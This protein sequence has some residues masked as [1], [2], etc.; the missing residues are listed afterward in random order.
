M[1]REEGLIGAYGAP[2]ERA[3]RGYIDLFKD[4][5]IGGVLFLSIL[6]L[7]LIILVWTIWWVW[8]STSEIKR[9]RTIVA[10]AKGATEG[11]RQAAFALRYAEIHTGL[12]ALPRIGACWREFSETL[13]RPDPDVPEGVPNHSTVVRN[14]RRPQEYFTLSNAGMSATVLRSWPGIL[15]GIGLVLTFVGL[16]AALGTAADSLAG[17][18][19]QS[20]MVNALR[21]LLRTAGAKFY[22]SATALACSIV[23]GLIQRSCLKHLAGQMHALNDALEERLQFDPMASTSRHQLAAI[24]AQRDQMRQLASDIGMTVGETVREA[25]GASNGELVDG[26]NA[27]VGKLDV[28][29]NETGAGVSQKVGEKLDQALSETLDKME[30]TLRD[31]QGSL[32]A[33]PEEIGEAVGA[34]K[35]ASGEMARQ[36]HDSA[37]SSVQIASEALEQTISQ[38]G[39]AAANDLRNIAEPLGEAVGGLRDASAALGREMMQFADRAETLGTAIGEGAAQHGTL[40]ESLTVAAATH[41]GIARD[42][43][44]LASRIEEVASVL[45]GSGEGINAGSKALSRAVEETRER[46]VAMREEE[47]EA[48]ESFQAILERSRDDLER[49]MQRYEGLDEQFTTVFTQFQEAIA[50]QQRDLARHVGE[51]DL[52]FANAVG[53]LDGQIDALRDALE[54]PPQRPVSEPAAEAAE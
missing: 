42:N 52:R 50:N 45:A 40:V 19:E 24:E 23:L 13:E 44:A 5:G 39:Q 36:L 4:E 33:L 41:Q 12:G 53:A 8:R 29:A 22:A 3:L 31:V 32:R 10:R 47:R 16:I 34:L 6:L 9:S 7:S 20:E 54:T 37:A 1:E 17:Q 35:G 28:L 21:D 2:V 15:V 18:V 46:A 14:E 11:E 51:I 27:V 26:L 43:R 25:M 49:H 48:R 38:A 30:A